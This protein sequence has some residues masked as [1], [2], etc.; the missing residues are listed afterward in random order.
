MDAIRP[1]IL[2]GLMRSRFLATAAL[3]AC[4][5]LPGCR[6]SGPQPRYLVIFSQCNNS[7]PY[8]AAQN[9]RLRELW[10]RYPD[11]KLVV[12]DAQQDNSRQIGQI[13]TAIRQQPDLLIVAPNERAPLALPL[14]EAMAA[15]IPVICLERDVALPNYT[16]WISADNRKIGEMAGEF[17]VQKLKEK[18]GTPRG[19]VVELCGL[20]GVEAEIDRQEGAHDVWKRYPGIKVVA[21]VVADWLQSRAK[22]RMTEILSAVPQIDIVYGHNDPMAV[23]AYLAAKEKGREHEMLFVGIDGLAG[24]SGGIEKVRDGILAATFVYPLCV[25]QAVEV[26]NQILR[27]PGFKPPKNLTVASRMV[28]APVQP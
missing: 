6:E 17:I 19:N 20:K 3:L 1:Q 21:N 24:P 13:E 7:E 12:M 5:W 26:G 27:D 16:T 9:A 8:R 23:G 25:D 11:V 28:S 2:Q 4:L 22:D 18:Y 14:G 15:H 10:A